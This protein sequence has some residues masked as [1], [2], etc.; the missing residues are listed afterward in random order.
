MNRIEFRWQCLIWYIAERCFSIESQVMPRHLTLK[1]V[2]KRN[3]TTNIDAMCMVHLFAFERNW[4]CFSQCHF[5]NICSDLN[6]VRSLYV[7]LFSKINILERL[8]SLKLVRSW[9]YQEIKFLLFFEDWVIKL[10]FLLYYNSYSIISRN[11]NVFYLYKLM[12]YGHYYNIYI[13][14]IFKL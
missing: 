6:S 9:N 10:L 1:Y 12:H 7:I 8:N 3:S 14:S 5:L 11:M 2:A 4:L 13:Y